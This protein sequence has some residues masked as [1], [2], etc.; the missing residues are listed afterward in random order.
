MKISELTIEDI[1]TYLVLDTEDEDFN[2]DDAY[3]MIDSYIMD[4]DHWNDDI[5]DD[6][7]DV[8]EDFSDSY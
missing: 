3:T 4:S 6:E 2:D 5:E 7:V 1:K 8:M